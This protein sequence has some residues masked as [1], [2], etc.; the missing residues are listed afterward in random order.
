MRR[1]GYRRLPRTRGGGAR[2]LPET[3]TRYTHRDVRGAF[4]IGLQH[5]QQRID[6]IDGS[7]HHSSDLPRVELQKVGTGLEAVHRPANRGGGD[8]HERCSQCIRGLLDGESPRP[9]FASQSSTYCLPKTSVVRMGKKAPCVPMTP[10]VPMKTAMMH[11]K[12][13]CERH[14]KPVM[15][16]RLRLGTSRDTR[17]MRDAAHRKWRGGERLLHSLEIFTICRSERAIQ[18]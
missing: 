7:G 4:V 13:I 9:N 11:C 6:I 10:H 12:E 15:S 17:S 2:R 3:R 16:G 8:T 1:R 5:S 14:K 18:V